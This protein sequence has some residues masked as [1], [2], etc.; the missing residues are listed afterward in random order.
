MDE[1][2]M[3]AGLP[4]PDHAPVHIPPVEQGW[5]AMQQQL[6][7]EWPVLKS[8]KGR[9]QWWKK[10][11]AAACFMIAG[12][13]AWCQYAIWEYHQ[14]QAALRHKQEWIN[15][16]IHGKAGTA[17]IR[18][19]TTDTPAVNAGVLTSDDTRLQSEP[20]SN[21]VTSLSSGK[22]VPVAAPD[23]AGLGASGK[24]KP[25]K[26]TGSSANGIN[27][28]GKSTRI[29]ATGIRSRTSGKPAHINPGHI[30]AT[31]SRSGATGRTTYVKS[32]STHSKVTG[33]TTYAKSKG[34]HSSASSKPA[35]V[36]NTDTRSS[37]VNV[38]D[39]PNGTTGKS[40]HINTTDLRSAATHQTG[41]TSDAHGTNSIPDNTLSIPA[42]AST[43]LLTLPLQESR[44][45]QNP[46][47]LSRPASPTLTAPANNKQRR[48]FHFEGWNWWLQWNL[49]VP[50]AG[51]KYYFTGADGRFQGYK[52]LVPAIRLEKS[53][54]KSALSL[55][56]TPFSDNLLRAWK[57]KEWTEMYQQ[58]TVPGGGT[59]YDSVFKSRA[60]VKQFGWGAALQYHYPVSD[61]WTVSAGVQTNWWT[62]GGAVEQHV[63][64]GLIPQTKDSAYVAGTDDWKGYARFRANA[65][66]ET[67]YR[68][69]HWQAGIRAGIPLNKLRADSVKNLSYPVQVEVMIRWNISLKKK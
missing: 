62:K 31:D 30:P 8:H 52:M 13:L 38:T 25:V 4:A 60:L 54:G 68:G 20:D 28:T 50:A 10:I 47:A 48:R 34:T 63:T 26:N 56:I 64:R 3:N 37:G 66:L 1:H 23:A 32:K 55:D 36:T 39:S 17:H 53:I 49:S 42:Y 18:R 19:A 65:V 58:D 11:A 44:Y 6:D 27:A 21:T 69:Q 59:R 29:N 41:R 51:A 7:V 45:H 33:K 46:R 14:R 22:V 15:E 5:A 9:I 40:D 16:K 2:Q 57:N 35:Y 43:P 12:T 61:H 67:Y 24:I